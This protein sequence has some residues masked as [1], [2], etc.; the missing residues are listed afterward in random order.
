MACVQALRGEGYA[1]AALDLRAAGIE[2]DYWGLCDVRDVAAVARAVGE[3]AAVL[4]GI[5]AAVHCAGVFPDQVVPLHALP[6]ETWERTIAVNLT[7]A[8][9]L[10][11][12][13]LPGLM[14]APSGGLVLTASVAAGQP[15]PGAAA[16]A[17]AKAGVGA[18]ARAL[19]LEYAHLGVRV[20][21]VSP[22]W[23][24]TP[25]AAPALDSPTLR[26]RIEQ[27]IP[28]GRVAAASEVAEAIVWLLSPAARHLTGQ[29][30]VIDGGQSVSAMLAAG[31]VAAVW[32]R[33]EPDAARTSPPK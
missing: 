22:G 9:A 1:V 8:F 16:Y 11:R 23:M 25:M 31:D 5:D 14:A 30:V 24:E 15:Q 13:V 3:A 7:G 10:A 2:A 19:A 18:L 26:E 21:S 4:G 12:A 6:P 28:A 33:L 29:D 32:R 17:A 27:A 20:N